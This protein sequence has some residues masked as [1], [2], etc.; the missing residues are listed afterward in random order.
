MDLERCFGASVDDVDR[1]SSVFAHLDETTGK[2]MAI[3]AA[4]FFDVLDPRPIAKTDP[5]AT[6]PN[7]N[8][9]RATL[10]TAMNP[11]ASLPTEKKGSFD[12]VGA[13][14]RVTRART[15]GRGRAT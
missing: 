10:P 3:G 14:S 15:L 12:F 7:A 6:L 5:M 1:V 2:T 8:T 13:R 11:L 4:A 9:P